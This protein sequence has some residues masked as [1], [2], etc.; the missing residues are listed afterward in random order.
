MNKTSLLGILI[1]L[2]AI[3]CTDPNVIGLEVQPTSENIT[4]SNTS[5]TG[6]NSNTESED[7]LRTDE[8]LNLILGE[9]SNDDIFGYNNASFL[10]Q[11]LLTENNIDL[12]DNPIVDSVILSY[13]YSGYYGN[14]EEFTS[15]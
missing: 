10:T 7:S 2:I 3:S 1:G 12:G 5:F 15:E 4:I 14:L 6:I 9:I 13:A 8:A 11:I